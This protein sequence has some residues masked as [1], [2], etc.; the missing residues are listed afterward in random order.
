MRVQPCRND[1]CADSRL[2]LYL[3]QSSYVY[4]PSWDIFTQC[5]RGYAI[6]LRGYST[7]FWPTQNAHL[8][9]QHCDLPLRNARPHQ[10]MLT[11]RPRMGQAPLL[12]PYCSSFHSR[13]FLVSQNLFLIS[14][15]CLS[16]QRVIVRTI[17][18]TM[19]GE[20]KK[21]CNFSTLNMIW[22]IPLPCSPSLSYSL[23]SV[24]VGTDLVITSGLQQV[25]RAV[26]GV[27]KACHS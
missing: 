8:S 25:G 26:G 19:Q 9:R 23:T 3:S 11:Q 27:L 12:L 5:L 7:S 13:P 10:G 22:L 1:S 6:T 2:S 18:W 14:S 16:P 24:F 21:L 20:K 15:A 17:R 4:T